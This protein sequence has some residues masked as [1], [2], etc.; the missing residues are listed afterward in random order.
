MVDGDPS[1]QRKEQDQENSG[2]AKHDLG[3]A[4]VVAD[5]ITPESLSDIIPEELDGEKPGEA[6]KQVSD[7]DKKSDPEVE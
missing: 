1:D 5:Q 4:A 7:S 3:A 2:G 6:S